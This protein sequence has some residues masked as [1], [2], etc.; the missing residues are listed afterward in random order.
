MC[1]CMGRVF[2]RAA[3]VKKK[4]SQKLGSVGTAMKDGDVSITG[5]KKCC[6]MYHSQLHELESH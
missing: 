6:W 1:A 3:E 2:L 5:M 4:C